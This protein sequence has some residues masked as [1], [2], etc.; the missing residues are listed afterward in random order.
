MNDIV[1]FVV[2]ALFAAAPLA[3]VVTG[4][5]VF[6][7]HR[8]SGRS[9]PVWRGL[10]VA[11]GLFLAAPLAFLLA[12]GVLVGGRSSALLSVGLLALLGT[13]VYLLASGRRP[14]LFRS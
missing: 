3:A 4:Y 11:V 1:G 12:G 10:G 8:R 9:R 14:A 2:V 13:G 5:A 6:E 7:A